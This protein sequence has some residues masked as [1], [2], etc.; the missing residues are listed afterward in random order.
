M[1]FIPNEDFIIIKDYEKESEQSSKED[2]K[3]NNISFDIETNELEI[4]DRKK[5]KKEKKNKEDKK[6]E[7]IYKHE[8]RNIEP[9]QE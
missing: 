1:E 6:E 5:K 8:F 2:E 7:I 3:N 9:T 4:I